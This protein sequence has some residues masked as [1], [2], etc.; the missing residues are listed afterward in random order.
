MK[1][2]MICIVCPVGCRLSIDT[3]TLEVTGNRCP[4]GDKYAKTEITNPTRIVTSTVKVNSTLQRRVSVKTSDPI[5]KGKIFD[6]IDKLDS[7]DLKVPV[8][9]GDVVIENVFDTGVDVIV[10]MKLGE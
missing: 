10:T 8:N 2:E 1:K 5:P 9:I 7:V 3:D 6:L 4:R